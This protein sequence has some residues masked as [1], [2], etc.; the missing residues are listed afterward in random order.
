MRRPTDVTPECCGQGVTG[1]D[2][3]RNR[4]SDPPRLWCRGRG[5]SLPEPEPD[6]LGHQPVAAYGKLGA[7]APDGPAL[8]DHAGMQVAGEVGEAELGKAC[9][10]LRLPHH[11]L[12]AAGTGS[13]LLLGRGLAGPAD[14]I[15]VQQPPHGPH[16]RAQLGGDPGQ[17]PLLPD[18]AVG[19]IGLKVGEAE[20]GCLGGQAL[21]G[22]A[23]ATLGGEL[24]LWGWCQAGLV[25]RAAD[26]RCGGAEF[27][28]QL[29]QALLAARRKV[30]AQVG[31][32]QLNGA[33]AGAALLS[34]ED[35]EAA[36]DGEP[37]RRLCCWRR[38]TCAWRA[39]RPTTPRNSHR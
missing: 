5:W 3:L 23:T 14:L 20:L 2:V 38:Y 4:Y 37:A 9:L 25:E 36:A 33:V 7:D 15:V 29:R 19:E 21:V 1:R 26:D 35:G 8:L 28:G 34:V 18:D 32:A 22:A 30:G 16:V 24:G 6:H 27:S 10:S 11:C 17:R 31:E 12:C 39:G 13:H